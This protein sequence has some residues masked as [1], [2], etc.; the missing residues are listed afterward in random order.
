MRHRSNSP[1]DG[2]NGNAGNGG[3]TL[4]EDADGRDVEDDIVTKATQIVRE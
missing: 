1:C 2:V 4:Y 3:K